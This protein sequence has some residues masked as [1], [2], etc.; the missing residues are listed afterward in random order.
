MRSWHQALLG[1]A[2][3]CLSLSTCEG[4]EL[5]GTGQFQ[6]TYIAHNPRHI[7]Q[8]SSHVGKVKLLFIA[9]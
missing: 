8:L 4:I 7:E 3:R 1:V 9:T 6:C 5:H 2:E